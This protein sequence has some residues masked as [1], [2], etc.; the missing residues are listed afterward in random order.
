MII[1]KVFASILFLLLRVT[2][3]VSVELHIS[4]NRDIPENKEMARYKN[5]PM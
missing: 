5:E 1:M 2:L 4:R 3:C